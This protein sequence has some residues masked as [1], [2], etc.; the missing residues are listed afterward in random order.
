MS[1][2]DTKPPPLPPPSDIPR[3]KIPTGLGGTWSLDGMPSLRELWT[4]LRGLL[5]RS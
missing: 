4:L 5:H 1:V 3:E 2:L